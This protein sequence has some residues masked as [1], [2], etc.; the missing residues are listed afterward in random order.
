MKKIKNISFIAGL[1]FLFSTMLFYA[2]MPKTIIIGTV[3]DIFNDEFTSDKEFCQQVDKDIALMKASN[4][5]YVMIFP[6]GNWDP[7]TKHLKWERTDYLVKKIEGCQMKFIPLMLKE[8]Q[9][10]HYFP[11]WKFKEIKGMWDEYNLNNNNKNNRENVDFADPRVYPLVENYFKQVI[12]RYGKSPALSF[13]NIWN[14]PHYSS[15]A[16]HVLISFRN[17][18]MKKYLDLS[19]LRRA[20]GKEYSDWDEISPFL[21]DNWNSSMPQIDWAM[22]RNE[23]NGLLLKQLV[24]TLRKYDSV[25][26]VNANPVN[27]TWSN[28][29]NFG[30]YNIDNW[31]V[32]EYND[33]NGISYYPDGWERDHN[34]EPC[35]F[36]LHNLTFNTIRCL[37]LGREGSSFSSRKDTRGE[38]KN[39]IL[40]ELYTNVQ[41]G[42]ALNGYQTKESVNLLAWSALANDCK[43]LI[44]WQWKPFMR[45]RQS[46]GRGL[47]LV[48]GELAPRGEAVK[49]IGAVINK[50]GDTLFQAHLKTPQVAVLVDMVGLLKT[51]E[52]TTELS[53]NKF[54]YE[55][56]AGIFKSL[57]EDNITLD[58]LRMDKG[59]NPNLLKRYKII[60][61]PFQIVMRK[62]IADML[63]EYVRQGGWV[64]ADARTATV[65]ELDFAYHTNP[66]AGLDE[67][68]GAVRP[69][70]YGQKTYFKVRLKGIKG[71]DP[72]EF[73]GKYFKDEL[74]VK[75][76][77]NVIGTF[78]NNDPAIIEHR[79]G[80]GTA[81]L[82]AVPLG[83]S[84]FENPIN[85]VNKF[86]IYIAKQAGVTPY[87]QFISKT[88]GKTNNKAA[89]LDL[90][91]HE[92]NGNWLLYVINSENQPKSG[93]IE[94]NIEDNKNN[95]LR[96]IKSV[97]EI[98]S[99]NYSLFE[100]TDGKLSI[101]L[102]LLPNQVMVYFIE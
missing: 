2:Q 4:I 75:D 18:L 15:T 74:Q 92:L 83:A 82:S 94:I 87:A 38:K 68:F 67:L 93:T 69:D 42:L 88:P 13:Y 34:L 8:E 26:P 14:E 16:N 50:Y 48:N 27:T 86:I 25:H 1:I 63:K 37:S 73:D 71:Y 12:Q 20:W 49:D 99:E 11:L 45:G 96:R 64:V 19:S 7:T 78:E 5:Q 28:F 70:W 51:L 54:M 98:I 52:Q 72:C 59:I 97:K 95:S 102:N 17:W 55:S 85:P 47:C 23:L 81:I 9:C 33:I 84:Y 43:G 32:A 91:V 77:V 36:W 39:Y 61:L 24:Q 89:S 66:G 41:N 6:L 30:A 21:I 35:P 53:T 65:N 62:H 29:N 10:S 60:Y 79:F 22:F 58:I 90:K 40:T 46:L 44:Y 3:Y 100:Q 56:S 76:S 31:S 80:K 101:P 57:Y